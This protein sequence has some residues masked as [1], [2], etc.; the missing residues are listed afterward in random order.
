MEKRTVEILI[1]VIKLLFIDI[2]FSYSLITK[3]KLG[4]SKSN[5]KLSS[6]YNHVQMIASDTPTLMKVTQEVKLY[7]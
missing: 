5:L 4:Y 6:K 1:Y 2:L 7:I 3:T